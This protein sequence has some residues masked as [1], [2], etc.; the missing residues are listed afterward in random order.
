MIAQGAFFLGTTRLFV[1]FTTIKFDSPPC[2]HKAPSA[3]PPL[4]HL[5][6]DPRT[7]DLD[8]V[9]GPMLLGCS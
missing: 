5:P 1:L 6:L 9:W 4:L 8:V 2:V 7:G 3:G